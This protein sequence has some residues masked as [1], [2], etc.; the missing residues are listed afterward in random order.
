M[1]TLA[2]LVI[3]CTLGLAACGDDDDPVI[4]GEGQLTLSWAMTVGGAPATCADVGVAK[5]ETLSTLE[6]TALGIADRFPCQDLQGTTF[7]LEEGVYTVVV[8]IL[9]STDAAIDSA[10]SE[11]GVPVTDGDVTDLGLYTFDF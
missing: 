3:L 4:V 8:S 5:V 10:P 6:G 11:Q 7:P 9:D 1:R 2:P